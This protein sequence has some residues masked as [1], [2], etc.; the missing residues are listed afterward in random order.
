MGSHIDKW[1]AVFRKYFRSR[2][3][4]LTSLYLS[5]SQNL[6]NGACSPPLLAIVELPYS[7]FQISYTTVNQFR[8]LATSSTCKIVPLDQC[9][10]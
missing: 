9:N 5:F 2:N 8:T 10:L 4:S 3:A 1:G 7:F 6:L